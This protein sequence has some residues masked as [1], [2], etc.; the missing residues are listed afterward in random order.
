MNVLRHATLL[1]LV[2]LLALAQPALAADVRHQHLGQADPVNEGWSRVG[3]H[4]QV[5][6]GPVQDGDITAWRVDDNSTASGSTTSYLRTPSADDI[7]DGNT[8]GWALRLRLRVANLSDAID[9]SVFGEYS[10]GVTR[11]VLAFG[12][13]AAG[14]A[15]VRLH[16][17]VSN[18]V[19]TVPGGAL[20]YHLYELVYDP[21]R[22]RATLRVDGVTTAFTEYA[23]FAAGSVPAR[24]IFG[25]GQSTSTGEG[26]YQLVAW[27]VAGDT[28]Q[29]KILDRLDNCP[30]IQNNP[31]TDNGGVGTG[32]APDGIGDACQCGD[33]D[34]DGRVTLA[35]AGRI[36]QAL[37]DPE[38]AALTG[39]ELGRCAVDPDGAGCDVL[40]ASLIER[41]VTV[42]DLTLA[43]TCEV[44]EGYGARCGDGRC[45]GG[46]S[47]AADS[48]PDDCGR[49]QVGAACIEDAD[50]STGLCQGQICAAPA[51]VPGVP[52]TRRCGDGI[53]DPK[54]SCSRS[55]LFGCFEDCGPCQANDDP[56]DG[57]NAD[58]CIGD[59]DCT[60]GNL[61]MDVGRCYNDHPDVLCVEDS[62]CPGDDWC[63][64]YA[65]VGDMYKNSGFQGLCS[66]MQTACDPGF[67]Y[68][69]PREAAQAQCQDGDLCR[70]RRICHKPLVDD[71][72]AP[73][74]HA[75]KCGYGTPC[76][77]DEECSSGI[78]HN[79]LMYIPT[80]GVDLFAFCASGPV[81]DG[82]PCLESTDCAS[83][84]CNFGFCM[85]PG[86]SNGVPCTTNAACADGF[87]CNLGFCVQAGGLPNGVPCST[88]ATCAS[89]K[90][91]VNGVPICSVNGCGDGVCSSLES[92]GTVVSQYS[93]PIERCQADCGKCKAGHSCGLDS[94]CRSGDCG[95]ELLSYACQTRCGDGFCEGGEKCTTNVI[96]G[97]GDYC[98]SD[99]GACA[100]G[101][102]C[103]ANADC[104]SNNCQQGYC[105]P[106]PPTCGDLGNCS[107]G[108]LCSQNSD[109]ASDRCI[110]KPGSSTKY[111]IQSGCIAPGSYC[112]PGSSGSCCDFPGVNLSC[113]GFPT[114]YCNPD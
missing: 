75:R 32:S 18:Q 87:Y 10:T 60:A 45:T 93:T 44:A 76:S 51:S 103:D 96:A 83:G 63:D 3:E 6:Y 49:C 25:A 99:C 82:A 69:G 8:S 36:R 114:Y 90:C 21:A 11:Y 13:N 42:G 109:C 43:Q 104:A 62:D 34:G 56:N 53:C 38:G 48:C 92:C 5:V 101:F 110:G 70:E 98:K 17:G 46:E 100:N 31:N 29:D 72:G 57:V 9:F 68:F 67:F 33:L 55:G 102:R 73:P 20:G 19:Y 80:Q 24:V 22:A 65:F 94:D 71:C 28:D 14:D 107:N 74:L 4:A 61:C 89:G 58:Y 64:K 1:A 79:F 88:D 111:C 81:V 113:T 27:E 84:N 97:L 106:K 7:A 16:D 12:S 40:T 15:L 78:C 50:C 77:E 95:L 2:V 47:C 26:R 59:S 105:A 41:A 23:G 91:G 54:E 35:D 52:Y 112:G 30:F 37:A 108:S 39:P 85:P 66:D 86:Q